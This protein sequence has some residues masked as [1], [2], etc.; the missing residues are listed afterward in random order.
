MTRYISWEHP[1]HKIG[2]NI[3]VN[4]ELYSLRT[5]VHEIKLVE[6]VPFGLGLF[7][8]GYPQTFESDERVYHEA[9]VHPAMILSGHPETVLI[10]GCAEGCSLREIV[11]YQSVSSITMVDIDS[12]LVE[13]ARKELTIWNHGSFADPRVKL[14]FGD[15]HQLLP[16]LSTFD[17]ILLAL[18]DPLAPQAAKSFFTEEFFQELSSHLNKG[19]VLCTQ[20]GELD[21]HNPFCANTICATIGHVFDHIK[22]L[23]VGMP[24]YFADWLFVI[25]SN[26]NRIEGDPHE[27]W[28]I[29]PGLISLQSMMHLWYHTDSAVSVLQGKGAVLT[30]NS[31]RKS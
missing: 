5:Q 18:G 7:L 2:F 26:D 23:V 13:F 28:K 9:L 1:Y 27:K 12:E 4:K 10:V 25:A 3:P 22:T 16:S 14:L 6:T 17:V 8:D 20:A 21:Y 30:K 31:P 19:G 11:K 29:S 15:I 24:S